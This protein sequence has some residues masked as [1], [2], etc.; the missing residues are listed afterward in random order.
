M[1]ALFSRQGN[2]ALPLY[3]RILVEVYSYRALITNHLAGDDTAAAV[4]C[5]CLNNQ[6]CL[7]LVLKFPYYESPMKQVKR[8]LINPHL[9]PAPF[10][11]K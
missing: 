6:N 2:R 5:V 11:A 9:A 3:L 7:F 4:M 8:Y 1:M 10:P